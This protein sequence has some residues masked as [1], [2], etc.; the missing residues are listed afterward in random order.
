MS[1]S[2]SSQYQQ[3]STT[4]P[5][6]SVERSGA[7]EI[8][9][10]PRRRM[11]A[12][13]S[14]ITVVALLAGVAL[15]GHATDWAL[16]KLSALVGAGD[17]TQ[18]HC[19]A[20]GEGWCKEHNVPEAQCIECNSSLVPAVPDYGW[21]AEHGIAQCPLHHPDVAQLKETPAITQADFDRADRAIALLPRNENG[22]RCKHYRRRIQ[23]ASAE[24]IEKAGVDIAVVD[25]QPIVEAI[26]ANGEVS[27]DQTRFA[28]LAS[29][30]AG[31][32]WRVEKHLGER[33][34]KGE[35]LVLIDSAEIGR[36]KSDL[37]QAIA[38]LRV[39]QANVER[40]QPLSKEGAVAGKLVR[41]AEANLQEAQI[42]LLAAEQALANLGFSVD[43]HEFGELD[44]AQIAGRI[45]FLGLPAALAR[46]IEK[47]SA[48]SNLFAIRAP[49][50]GVVV[51]CKVVAGEIADTSTPIFA[52]AD[53]TKM[54]LMLD[55][56]QEDAEQLSL[57]QPVVFR[58]TDATNA[59]SFKGSVSW[60][61]TELDDKT[62]TVKV[63]VDMPNPD[64]RLRA[65]TFGAGRI[66]LR[67]EP[68]AVVIP[69]EAVHS[70]GDCKIVFVRDKDYFKEGAPKFFHVREIRLG[71]QD[72]ATSEVIAGLLPG[73]VVAGKNSTVLEAQLLKSNLG[74]GCA[75][76]AAAK[77][78]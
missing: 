24:A 63:R 10:P 51:E 17:G 61:S 36:A 18:S 72:G 48:T 58:A 23:F 52:V 13:I 4:P 53:V 60:I 27:Y 75:C 5:R 44:T 42:K 74:E 30:V 9:V 16:P 39:A 77:K 1:Q 64:G 35:V 69:T 29:R 65:N 57:G 37:L 55:A 20:D 11:R 32:V 15:W 67:E 46:E 31:T 2:D 3:L 54:W 33:V 12:S 34:S 41:E 7:A 22:S 59:L 49:L 45:K 26:T 50:D 62:R 6:Q 47:D 76:C 43:A 73:E 66:V 40:I 19:P 8:A 56:R 71:V 78:K 25:E 68:K 38:A 70:D 28:R 14:T 21:C